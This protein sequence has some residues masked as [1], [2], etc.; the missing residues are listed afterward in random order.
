M[1][2][3]RVC[4]CCAGVTRFRPC[5]SNVLVPC[6]KAMVQGGCLTCTLPDVDDR[7]R[8]CQ[9]ACYELADSECSLSLWIGLYC[10]GLLL[11][12]SAVVTTT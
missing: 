9:Q 8:H 6:E 12:L 7:C 3:L 4:V 5:Y 10:S 11:L 1:L 2:G